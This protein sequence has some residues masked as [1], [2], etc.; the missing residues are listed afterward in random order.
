MTLALAL[1]MNPMS[2][3]AEFLCTFCVFFFRRPSVVNKSQAIGIFIAMTTMN[4]RSLG[5]KA[6]RKLSQK[7]IAFN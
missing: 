7:K 1:Y 3:T 2:Q 4:T 6:L 5:G